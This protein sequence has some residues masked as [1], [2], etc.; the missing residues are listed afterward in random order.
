MYVVCI[1]LVT[2]DHRERTFSVEVVKCLVFMCTYGCD[3]IKAV[4]V[5][6]YRGKSML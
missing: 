5:E 2:T 6:G 4:P 1:L 3:V